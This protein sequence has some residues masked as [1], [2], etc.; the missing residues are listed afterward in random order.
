M[1]KQRERGATVQNA[2]TKL[3]LTDMVALGAS[4]SAATGMLAE[5]GADLAQALSNFD[6]IVRA[7]LRQAFHV[8]GNGQ[9]KTTREAK[10]PAVRNAEKG[11][12]ALDAVVGA[13]TGANA[14]SRGMTLTEGAEPPP[15]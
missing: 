10:S 15:F 9:P 8:G 13:V 3:S 1:S 12:R 5:P 11:I 14:V 4:L 7:S 6:G 2:I